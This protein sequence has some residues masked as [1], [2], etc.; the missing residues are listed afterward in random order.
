[1]LEP[2]GKL[3]TDA[4]GDTGAVIAA[5][6]GLFCFIMTLYNTVRLSRDVRARRKREAEQLDASLSEDPVPPDHRKHPWE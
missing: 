6:V 5:L 3:M 2:F 4:L 1:M